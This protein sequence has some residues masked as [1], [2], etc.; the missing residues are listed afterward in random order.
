MRGVD[1]ALDVRGDQ[2]GEVVARRGAD[3]LGLRVEEDVAGQLLAGGEL[4]DDR[5]GRQLEVLLGARHDA[6]GG[7]R[8]RD[9]LVDVDAD[10]VDVGVTGGVEDAVAGLAGDLEQ[11]VD[12]VGRDERWANFLPP[13]GSLN[14]AF[15][16][17]FVT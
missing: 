2:G 12:L 11:D 5:P 16:K 3:A 15:E 9:G 1:L 14:A 10:A 13:A 6:L 8:V 17:S 4:L 7:V